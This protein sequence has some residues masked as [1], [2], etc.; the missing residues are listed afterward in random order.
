MLRRSAAVA[1]LGLFVGA[2]SGNTPT[3]PTTTAPPAATTPPATTPEPAPEPS[4][5]AP[6]LVSLLG[7][8]VAQSRARLV[9]AT[10]RVIDGPNANR[11]ATTDGNGFFQI[12]GLEPGEAT[13]SVVAAN[14]LE[15]RFLINLNGG[16]QVAFVL[17][18][19]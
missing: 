8:V 2:C 5:P 1:V 6:T 9:N 7:I 16:G 10:V 4:P 15:A 13:V 19:R 12:D 14:Y 3:N 18:P 17:R 11:A